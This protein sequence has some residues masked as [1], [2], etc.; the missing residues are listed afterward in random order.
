MRQPGQ[1]LGQFGGHLQRAAEAQAEPCRRAPGGPPRAPTLLGLCLG[2]QVGSPLVSRQAVGSVASTS[3][4]QDK[5][6]KDLSF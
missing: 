2:T 4:F 5:E 1:N 6:R 3:S